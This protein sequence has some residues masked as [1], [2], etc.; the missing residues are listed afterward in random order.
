ME[1]LNVLKE[2][3]TYKEQVYALYET[4]FPKE[5]QKPLSCMEQW[6]Q[7]GKAELLAVVEDKE[8]I[9]LVMN[10]FSSS[11]VVLDYFA[12]APEKRSGGYGGK[13]VREL[14][15]R[16]QGQKYVFEIEKQDELAANAE[17]RKRRKA[18]YLRNGLKETGLFVHAYDT[19]FEILTPDGEITYKQY[20]DMLKEMLG[21]DLYLA[22][23]SLIEEK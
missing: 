16:F 15:K 7:E 18:F 14:V 10:M 3:K 2:G 17:D 9:G 8:F 11:A 6:A 21:K 22:S 20:E 1:F 13:A 12:I 19:D 4:A 23:P 5:E